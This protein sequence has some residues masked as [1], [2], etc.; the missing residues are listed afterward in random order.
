MAIRSIPKVEKIRE[1]TPQVVIKKT[2]KTPQ[3][4]TAATAA[5]RQR[6]DSHSSHTTAT[7]ANE[8]TAGV[9]PS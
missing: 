4:S 3:K 7:A 5:T 1:L 6:H 2:S 8:K 9:S